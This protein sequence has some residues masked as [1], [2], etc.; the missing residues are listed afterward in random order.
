MSATAELIV[1]AAA[2]DASRVLSALRLGARADDVKMSYWT[3]QD[4]LI[5]WAAAEGHAEIVD[6]IVQNAGIPAADFCEAIKAAACRSGPTAADVIR[7]LVRAPI[8]PALSAERRSAA[9]DD[10]LLAACRGNTGALDI[11]RELLTAGANPN[12]H[13]LE[14]EHDGYGHGDEEFSARLV[15]H[16]ALSF[17]AAARVRNE[18]AIALLL[19]AGADPNG[20]SNS[21]VTPLHQAVNYERTGAVQALVSAGAGGVPE[22][23]LRVRVYCATLSPQCRQQMST[24]QVSTVNPSHRFSRRWKQATRVRDTPCCARFWQLRASMC[25]SSLGAGT[26]QRCMRRSWQAM[27]SPSLCSSLLA[28]TR[29]LDAPG[30]TPYDYA[31]AGRFDGLS[32]VAPDSKARVL[33]A[34]APQTASGQARPG[35]RV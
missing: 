22:R 9:F 5:L 31:M 4:P 2:R 26:G 32:G 27:L 28:Q 13:E 7:A 25:T 35:V 20:A 12:K 14:S 3:V 18:A 15:V 23:A 8:S 29:L 10:A 30:R 11:M 33:A 6:H 17:A 21:D 1:A 19:A 24:L 34:L 16:T